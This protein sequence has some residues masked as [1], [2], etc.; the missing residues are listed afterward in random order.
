[1]T[2]SQHATLQ[3]PQPSFEQA[4]YQANKTNQRELEELQGYLKNEYL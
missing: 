1:M 2:T 3:K 4:I